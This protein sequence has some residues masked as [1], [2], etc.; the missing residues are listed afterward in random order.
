MCVPPSHA[1]FLNATRSDVAHVWPPVFK[2]DFNTTYGKTSIITNFN[3]TPTYTHI[4]DKF[5]RRS[6]Y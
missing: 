6:P 1:S 4:V 2:Y 5:F 3:A